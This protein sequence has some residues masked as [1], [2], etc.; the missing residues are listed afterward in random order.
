MLNI[1]IPGDFIT[2]TFSGDLML[3]I[4]PINLVLVFAMIFWERSNPQST[5]L[6]LLVMLMFPPFGFILYLF[7]GQT[8]YSK[9][10]FKTKAQD[11]LRLRTILKEQ[12]MTL[13]RSHEDLEKDHPGSSEFMN[14]IH[15]VSHSYSDDN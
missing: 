6:W 2:G 4:I 15:N 12:K 13:K 1:T 11:D 7:F 9:Y 5:L 3:F 14:I 10:A 8:F